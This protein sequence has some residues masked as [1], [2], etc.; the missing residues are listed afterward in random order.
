MLR[1]WHA[2]VRGLMV[3]LVLPAA[4]I[5]C[6]DSTAIND[7][8]QLS[9]VHAPDT[10]GAPGWRLRDT[11]VVKLTD[12]EGEPLS[13][14]MIQWSI[15]LGGGAVEPLA[16]TTDAGGKAAA[17]W[18]L[19]DHGLNRLRA[20]SPAGD[21]VTFDVNAS[22]FR[23]DAFDSD[24]KLGCGLLAGAIWCWG[25]QWGFNNSS[26]VAPLVQG[27][28]AGGGRAAE[29]VD[30]SRQ[31]TQIA[32]DGGGPAFCALDTGGKPWCGLVDWTDPERPRFV[33]SE[34]V[35]MPSLFTI[36]NVDGSSSGRVFCGLATADSTVWCLEAGE[37]AHA[38][39]GSPALAALVAGNDWYCGI[40]ADSMAVC[41]GE[42]PLGDGK[43][44]SSTVPVPVAGDHRFT[45][46][47]AEYAY[48]CGLTDQAEVFCWTADEA[49]SLTASDVNDL[50]I[51]GDLIMVLQG[52]T[53]KDVP[54]P[55]N[56]SVP[57][58]PLTGLDG[59]PVAELGRG[60]MSC[61]RL[62]DG[63]IYCWDELWINST[64]MLVFS[65][66]PVDS[67]ASN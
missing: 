45:K 43:T 64:L 37:E 67:P 20:S 4:A 2:V 36:V 53:V 35:G 26:S 19:G 41:W 31:Y 17:L 56:S 44:Q 57:I 14:A 29:L 49:P 51:D 46:L 39:A 12:E 55:R 22:A 3:P 54:G 62:V 58:Q 15:R 27:F 11:I 50:A 34:A 63:E 16:D 24:Y 33:V 8:G 59:L 13:G 18:T 21:S 42:G 40:R 61:V 9:I 52:H 32:V 6:S 66:T 23:V 48:V 47:R 65:Y 60:S 10:A 5:G 25:G 7:S 38:V 30:D 28:L 1:S